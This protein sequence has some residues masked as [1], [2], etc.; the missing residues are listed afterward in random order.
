MG[1]NN[2]FVED[3]IAFTDPKDPPRE[4]SYNLRKLRRESELFYKNLP[5]HKGDRVRL[6]HSLKIGRG[7]GWYPWRHFLVKGAVGTAHSVNI[8]VLRDFTGVD[9]VFDNESWV[10]IDGKKHQ[11]SEGSSFCISIDNL[12]LNVD[13]NGCITVQR[14]VTIKKYV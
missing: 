10:D 9:V 7:D 5:I 3:L 8:N 12:E 6:A 4:I 2:Q 1:T 13:K 14:E 11:V